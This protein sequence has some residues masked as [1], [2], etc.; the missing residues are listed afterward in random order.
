MNKIGY[1]QRTRDYYRAQGFS[2]DYVWAH[3]DEIPFSKLPRQL[4]ESTVTI[5]TTAVVEP[6]VPKLMR[7]AAS[8]AFDQVP[9][10]FDTSELAW[11]KDTTHTRDRQSYF[12]LEILQDLTRERRIK[13][14]AERFHFVPTDYSQS[15]TLEK[16]APRILQ[17]CQE[18][19]V[20]LAILIPL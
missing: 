8:Y 11:D 14:L 15:N 12:P 13:G 17:A 16:D 7:A 10:K 19:Q 2:K 3:Y 9:E 1:M 18:D 6:E 20:D 4:D 5:V